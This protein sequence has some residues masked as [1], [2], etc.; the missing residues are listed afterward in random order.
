MKSKYIIFYFTF[1]FLIFLI[2]HT[3]FKP[4]PFFK[5]N[6]YKQAELFNSNPKN[7]LE[8]Y[9]LPMS[10]SFGKLPI[11]LEE[12]ISLNEN[13]SL[14]DKIELSTKITRSIQESSLGNIIKDYNQIMKND[15]EYWEICSEA[16]KIFVFLMNQLNETA[17]VIW[18]NGH[19]ITEVWN[20]DHWIFVDPS[21]NTLAKDKF[22]KKNV[23]FTELVVSYPDIEF[24][25]IDY[26]KSKLWDYRDDAE[27]LHNILKNIEIIFIMNNKEIFSFHKTNEKIKRVF[28]SM[29]FNENFKAKQFIGFK[30]A[31]KVG[32]MGLHMFKLL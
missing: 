11:G 3:F 23:S 4:F 25:T 18:V 31:T 1:F 15:L 24:R 22:T 20:N 10:K 17:R 5:V 28:S 6:Y 21:S 13:A 26:K 14:I 32:N 12:Q 29:F 30:K 8:F 7:D 9:S 27:K 2:N 19:T 16:A